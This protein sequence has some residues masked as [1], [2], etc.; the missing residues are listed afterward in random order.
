MSTLPDVIKEALQRLIHPPTDPSASL[1][2]LAKIEEASASLPTLA[3]HNEYTEYINNAWDGKQDLDLAKERKNLIGDLMTSNELL[4]NQIELS[5]NAQSLDDELKIAWSAAETNAKIA[6]D[7]YQKANLAI[8]IQ[9]D[10]LQRLQARIQEL[11]KEK[12]IKDLLV[13]Q[14]KEVLGEIRAQASA[15]NDISSN[16]MGIKTTMDIIAQNVRGV[17]NADSEDGPFEE[18]KYV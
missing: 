3:E 1:T 16:V 7:V 12:S 4:R 2:L 11:E 15:I 8:K 18:M 14:H 13:T 17:T 10:E 5:Q 6:R 9:Q